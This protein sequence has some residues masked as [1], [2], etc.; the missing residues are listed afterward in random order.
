MIIVS[1]SQTL[2]D[3][4]SRDALIAAAVSLVKDA[5]NAP[6]CRAFSISADLVDLRVL[7]HYEEWETEDDLQR[8]LNS[9]LRKGF[10]ANIASRLLEST[11]TKYQ[12]ELLG[13]I[14]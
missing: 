5:R 13:P 9:D 12:A 6:G 2:S 7:H 14:A 10:Q 8:H 1:A 11:A 4:Q 3:P